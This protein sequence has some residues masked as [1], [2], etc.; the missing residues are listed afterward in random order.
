MPAAKG[1]DPTVLEKLSYVIS[2]R[3]REKVLAALVAGPKTPA[4]IAREAAPD[5]YRW[6]SIVAGIIQST[7]FQMRRS[8]QP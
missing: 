7:P 1:K 2:S 4:Q 6:A 8:G 3:Q 5:N